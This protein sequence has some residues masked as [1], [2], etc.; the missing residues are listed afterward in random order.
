MHDDAPIS[1]TREAARL[2][3]QA[4]Q[5]QRRGRADLAAGAWRVAAQLLLV[6]AGWR[7][8]PVDDDPGGGRVEPA[9]RQT[10]RS[11]NR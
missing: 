5:W 6:T 9:Q 1:P 4:E 2:M 8:R 7:R 10:R 11:T 3:A